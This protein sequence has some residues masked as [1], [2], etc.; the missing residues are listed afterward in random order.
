MQVY[1]SLRSYQNYLIDTNRA[2]VADCNVMPETGLT[3]DVAEGLIRAC[4]TLGT[5]FVRLSPLAPH[6]RR[7]FL[8]SAQSKFNY[9]D[10]DNAGAR[11]VE[12]GEVEI[13]KLDNLD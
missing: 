4:P 9:P 11:W 5:E 3:D 1:S 2:D 12:T 8:L 7:R 6:G 13:V 10:D